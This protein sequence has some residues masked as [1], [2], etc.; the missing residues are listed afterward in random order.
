MKAPVL[1]MEVVFYKGDEGRLCGWTA[2]PP[3]R[4]RFQG[5]TMASGRDLPHDLAQFVVEATL[6]LATGSGA[7]SQRG[8][9]SRAFPGAAVRSRANS[10]FVRTVRSSTGSSVS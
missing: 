3:K 7:C 4:R 8:R 10:L 9:P 6:G 5:T 1:A 2:A